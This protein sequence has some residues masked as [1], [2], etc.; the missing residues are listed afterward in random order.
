[1]MLTQFSL[2][3]PLFATIFLDIGLGFNLFGFM[4][5]IFGISGF[6]VVEMLLGPTALLLVG[7]LMLYLGTRSLGKV[8]V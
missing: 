6:Y 8:E 7:G 1:M 4:E 2:I 5:S 3:G